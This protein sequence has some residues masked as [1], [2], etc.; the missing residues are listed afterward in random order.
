MDYSKVREYIVALSENP[1]LTEDMRNDLKKFIDE[2]DESAGEYDRLKA[3]EDGIAGMR[4]DFKD[5]RRDYVDKILTRENMEESHR[6]DAR[7]DGR[8]EWKTEKEDIFEE[9]VIER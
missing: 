3:M 4:E 8:D 1:E 7:R 6:K 2:L 5:F 9:E